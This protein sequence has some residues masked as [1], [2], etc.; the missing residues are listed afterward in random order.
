VRLDTVAGENCGRSYTRVFGS[1]QGL[2]TGAASSWS[3]SH[4]ECSES[5]QMVLTVTPGKA[6]RELRGLPYELR[7]DEEPPVSSTTLLPPEAGDPVWTAMPG[8]TPRE[9]VPGSSFADAPLLEAGSYKTTLMPG[10]LQLYKVKADWGQRLQAQVG[11]PKLGSFAA[12]G[13]V[14]IRYLDIALVSPTGEDVYA[15][16]AEKVPGGS[17]KRAVL[18]ERGATQGVMTKEIRYLNR[19]GANNQD[20]GTSMPGEYYVSVSLTKNG[21]QE[22]PFAIPMTLTVGVRGTAG[23][24]EAGV[25]RRRDPGLGRLCHADPGAHRGAVR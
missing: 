17:G 11:V 14:G 18:T 22:Q 21:Q 6:F 3:N 1:E 20:T 8:T 4:K 9:I 7:I 23:R 19:D 10:E 13:V 2:A 12:G 5:D 15:V 24:R 16:F 25:R